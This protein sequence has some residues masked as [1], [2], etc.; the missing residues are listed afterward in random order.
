[1]DLLLGILGTYLCGR[2]VIRDDFLEEVVRELEHEVGEGTYF[3][4]TA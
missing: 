4:E 2:E 1:M 3:L